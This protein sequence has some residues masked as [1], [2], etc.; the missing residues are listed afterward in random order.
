MMGSV[1]GMM[2]QMGIDKNP[3]MAG[4]MQNLTGMMTKM[5]E[6]MNTEQPASNSVTD[7]MD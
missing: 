2:S 4:M 3:E 6:G 5:T 1:T 7:E